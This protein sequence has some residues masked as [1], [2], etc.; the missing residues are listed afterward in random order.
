MN[1][2][3]PLDPI[4]E[5]EIYE[6]YN[7]FTKGHTSIFISHRLSSTRF[8]DRILFI[9]NGQIAEEGDHYSLMKKGGKYKEMYDMQSY[10]YK[11]NIR[12]EKDA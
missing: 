1:L 3:L 5:N 12:G 6:K 4:A 2:L 11:N 8:C 7:E 10:Y 9:E